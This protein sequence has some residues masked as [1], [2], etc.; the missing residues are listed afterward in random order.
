M[1]K[2]PISPTTPAPAT[3]SSQA[4]PPGDLEEPLS[5]ITIDDAL[6]SSRTRAKRQ[7]EAL[8]HR[9]LDHAKA[10]GEDVRYLI[11]PKAVDKG[12]VP[13]GL[14]SLLKD[15]AGVERLG[16]QIKQEILSDTDARHVRTFFM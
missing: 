8:P 14:Q 16:E 6:T 13:D 7:L 3:S 4:Y 15:V 10:F 12:S 2:Q 11:A 1:S 5:T 9:V